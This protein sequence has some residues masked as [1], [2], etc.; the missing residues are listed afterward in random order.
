MNEI[1]INGVISTTLNE[2][3]L[4]NKFIEW[5]EANDMTFAGII[6]PLDDEDDLNE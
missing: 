3:E 4:S 1:E 2:D 5:I 6:N